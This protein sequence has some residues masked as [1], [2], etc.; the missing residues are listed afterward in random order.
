M[1]GTSS[2]R[3]PEQDSAALNRIGMDGWIE[4]VCLVQT[5]NI[6]LNIFRHYICLH[7]LTLGRDN[8]PELSCIMYLT[9]FSL[10]FFMLTWH[11]C[12]FLI[13]HLFRGAHH[14]LTTV[15]RARVDSSR[16][17]ISFYTSYKTHPLSMSWITLILPA[18]SFSKERERERERRDGLVWR[19]QLRN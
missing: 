8:P 6:K 4:T 10:L 5:K 3:N 18:H 7:G 13:A 11:C 15:Y 12:P 9:Y 19:R 17:T 14:T 1:I 2:P 16:R